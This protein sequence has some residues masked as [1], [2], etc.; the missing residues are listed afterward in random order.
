MSSAA[1]SASCAAQTPPLLRFTWNRNYPWE[2]S[3]KVFLI[4]EKSWS[5]PKYSNLW[6]MNSALPKNMF[7]FY[8]SYLKISK[9]LYELNNDNF[10]RELHFEHRV[11]EWKQAVRVDFFGNKLLVQ[12]D[13]VF[14]S[15]SNC[16]NSSSVAPPDGKKKIIFNFSYNMT[17]RVGVGVFIRYF[18]LK[19]KLKIW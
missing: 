16:R 7:F 18:W 4:S 15:E 9:I 19:W 2:T 11:V 6:Q 14:D 1:S 17:S 8:I 10:I 13:E 5:W 3:Y 12:P